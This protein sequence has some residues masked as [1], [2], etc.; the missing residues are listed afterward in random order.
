[1]QIENGKSKKVDIRKALKNLVSCSF[2]KALKNF[3]CWSF[4]KASK[5]YL[6]NML[7]YLFWTYNSYLCN[8]LLHRLVL[9]KHSVRE[10]EYYTQIDFSTTLSALEFKRI[11]KDRYDGM[12]TCSFLFY[13]AWFPILQWDST[14]KLKFCLNKFSKTSS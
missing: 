3:A 7:M 13:F 2:L 6:K 1:M 14:Q 9:P 4:S 10:Y 12:G 5:N 8:K 11:I